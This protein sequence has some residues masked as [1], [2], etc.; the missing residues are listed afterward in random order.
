M[1]NL[2]S[3]YEDEQELLVNVKW[4]VELIYK[5]HNY[6]VAFLKEGL[7]EALNYLFNKKLSHN[8]KYLR[9]ITHL[10]LHLVRK[11]C[12]PDLLVDIYKSRFICIYS[13]GVA[14]DLFDA[15]LYNE[16]NELIVLINENY[17]Q[18]LINCLPE[19]E[20]Y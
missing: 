4:V 3:N 18:Q 20:N 13:L 15:P 17:H 14:D 5:D 1:F 11:I 7:L 9:L 2:R 12:Q 16:L 8:I 6:A 19:S 10:V